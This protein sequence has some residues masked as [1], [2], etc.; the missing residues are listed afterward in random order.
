MILT[1]VSSRKF[2]LHFYNN[3][4]RVQI[5]DFIQKLVFILT[6]KPE[7]Q[8]SKECMC[9]LWNIGMHDYQESLTTRQTHRQT[10]NKVIPMCFYALQ[11]T[12]KYH[13]NKSSVIA[14]H[15]RCDQCRTQRLRH[16]LEHQLGSDTRDM[17]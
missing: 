7:W 15:K 5:L 16:L 4:V 14:T 17:L 11:A 8:H 10:Q 3:N 6:D 2:K 1:I 13:F 12:Q 9:C